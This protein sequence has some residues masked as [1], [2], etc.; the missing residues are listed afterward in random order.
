LGARFK[1]HSPWVISRT[2]PVI[3]SKNNSKNGP[4]RAFLLLAPAGDQRTIAASKHYPLETSTTDA[5]TDFLGNHASKFTRA[6]NGERLSRREAHE[7]GE[8]WLKSYAIRLALRLHR[9]A[10]FRAAHNTAKP[11][12][13]PDASV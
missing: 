8:P 6:P 12:G 10:V 2:M 3:H 7:L 5:L 1:I 13:S 11:A 4:Q 9:R